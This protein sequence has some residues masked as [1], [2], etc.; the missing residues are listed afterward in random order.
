MKHKTYLVSINFQE[1]L[2]PPHNLHKN[3]SKGSKFIII[4]EKSK[5]ITLI[6]NNSK[7]NE[8][9]K[10]LIKNQLTCDV[11]KQRRRD[12]EGYDPKKNQKNER[13]IEERKREMHNL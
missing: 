7:F 5:S 4:N 6:H 9:K 13:E 10:K 11:N 8:K 3:M 12:E 1:Y 2:L